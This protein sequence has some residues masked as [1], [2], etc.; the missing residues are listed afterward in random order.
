[1]LPA[2]T[3]DDFVSAQEGEVRVLGEEAADL[4]DIDL[5]F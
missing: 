2:G 4:L 5:G 1:M 3:L